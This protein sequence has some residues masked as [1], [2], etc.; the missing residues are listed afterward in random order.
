[1]FVLLPNLASFTELIAKMAEEEIQVFSHC[2]CVGASF[3]GRRKRAAQTYLRE[4]SLKGLLQLI[5]RR[6]LWRICNLGAE[7]IDV[8]GRLCQILLWTQFPTRLDMADNDFCWL[9]SFDEVL[10][11]ILVMENGRRLELFYP[12]TE[13]KDCQP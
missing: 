9:K 4:G 12:E 7:K 1:M 8:F 10:R 13:D 6:F 11:Q 5:H 3:C 2:R